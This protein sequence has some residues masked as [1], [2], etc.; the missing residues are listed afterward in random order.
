MMTLCVCTRGGEGGG[1]ERDYKGTSLLKIISL[2]ERWG[3]RGAWGDYQ[4]ELL[5]K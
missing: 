1:D 3:S 4:E 2:L 5:S